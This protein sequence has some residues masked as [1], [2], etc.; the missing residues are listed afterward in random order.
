M[1]F[2]FM[3]KRSKIEKFNSNAKKPFNFYIFCGTNTIFNT[4]IQ[5]SKLYDL[6]LC[7]KK[8][9]NQKEKSC[10]A[11]SDP[12]CSWWLVECLIYGNSCFMTF[13]GI[14]STWGEKYYFLMEASMWDEIEPMQGELEHQN[15][16]QKWTSE[17]GE[18]GPDGG[19][20]LGSGSHSGG[21]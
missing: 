15:K 7:D 1:N 18:C 14:F 3:L 9:W 6:Y 13:L 16:H 12:L 10:C 8:T 4:K 19:G 11:E 21:G 17:P 2:T 5:L 20:G